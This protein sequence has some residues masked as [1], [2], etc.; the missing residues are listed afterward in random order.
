[1]VFLLI[2]LIHFL[3]NKILAQNSLCLASV[4]TDSAF[5]IGV[6]SFFCHGTIYNNGGSNILSKGFCWDVNPNP[7]L[8]DFYNVVLD[9]SSNYRGTISGLTPNTTYYIRAYARNANAVSYGN[10]L[11]VTTNSLTI[12]SFFKGGYIFHIDSSSGRV[13]ICSPDDLGAAQWGCNGM[14]ISGTSPY[15]GFGHSNTGN[16]LAGCTELNSA[17][18]LCEN[19][20]YL[21]YNDWY[22]PSDY[23]LRE[24][25]RA[26][27]P[28]QYANFTSYGSS[29]WWSS[30]QY[31]TNICCPPQ[32]WNAIA[33]RYD[34]VSDYV[35]YMT[36]SKNELLKVRPVRSHY[37]QG[38]YQSKFLITNQ[39]VV[40]IT[41]TTARLGGYVFDPDTTMFFT[42]GFVYGRLDSLG[43]F[44]N[45]ISLSNQ[46]GPL[47]L[48]IS[49]L[50]EQTSYFY[51]TYY[52][53]SID[54]FYG[55]S[56]L[57]TTTNSPYYVGMNYGGGRVFYID[58]TGQTALVA[59]DDNLGSLPWGCENQYF[60][61]T[62]ESIGSGNSNTSLILSLCSDTGTAMRACSDLVTNGYS[63]WYLPSWDEMEL[64]K[65]T[66]NLNG[67]YWTSSLCGIMSHSVGI[68]LGGWNMCYER[69]QSLLV[70]P[71]RTVINTSNRLP[72]ISTNFVD[73]V[74]HNSA[75]VCGNLILDSNSQIVSKGFVYSIHSNPTLT[76]SYILNSSSG[77]S[78]L[79]NLTNLNSSTTYFVRSFATNQAGTRYGNQLSFTTTI[80]PQSCGTSS[81][82]PID[83]DGNIYPTQIIG[84]QCWMTS[85]LKVTR[86]RNGNAVTNFSIY[87]GDFL[88]DSLFGK[89]YGADVV[90]DTRGICP[91]GWHVPF[92]SEWDTLINTLGGLNFAGG[93]LKSV[94]SNPV[95]DG[96]DRP[97]VGATNISLFSAKP[98]GMRGPYFYQFKGYYAW[99]WGKELIGPSLSSI[100]IYHQSRSVEK[101][102]FSTNNNVGAGYS[103]SI[104]CIK[105]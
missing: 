83:I 1:V 89:L 72:L 15:L 75:R 44:S 42:S 34:S 104:R 26:F 41:S 2:L 49:G 11:I 40:E 53:N 73:S 13:L 22:L 84:N 31:N 27:G 82:P 39:N 36:F 56:V 77:G 54:T 8:G 25:L 101:M 46:N 95:I 57:F 20:T 69:F 51:K 94:N 65:T 43:S 67:W 70:H 14:E 55:D 28:T 87:N 19:F 98:G 12:G 10:Q 64:L 105:D 23:E 37:L 90:N 79:S 92:I 38:S 71:I 21:G 4:K 48:T 100:R 60:V 102:G 29:Y 74:F 30:S 45:Y 99:F 24:M 78:F 33:L 52:I 85:N 76:N 3:S 86:F 6:D 47:S 91:T 96:W 62:S 80:V 61:G 7:N 93:G 16:I 58:T 103:F 50:M 88:N 32:S 81:S 35:D 66:F 9:T 5:L 63:D 17:S 68:T 97:N 18:Q 59:S